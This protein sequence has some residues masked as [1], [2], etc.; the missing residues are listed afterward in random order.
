MIRKLLAYSTRLSKKELVETLIAQE[1]PKT[2]TSALLRNCRYVEV[3]AQRVAVVGNWKLTLDPLRGV[4]IEKAS[5][6]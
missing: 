2:W 3:N 1:N 5:E 4:L 6:N